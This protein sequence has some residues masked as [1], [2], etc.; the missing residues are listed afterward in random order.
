MPMRQLSASLYD[1]PRGNDAPRYPSTVSSA[2]DP[3]DSVRIVNF[4]S[5]LYEA[6]QEAQYGNLAIFRSG[7]RFLENSWWIKTNRYWPINE[8]NKPKS[9]SLGDAAI[10]QIV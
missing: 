6:K 2:D 10:E 3:I 9:L 7:Q 1:S 8:S 5:G 4:E